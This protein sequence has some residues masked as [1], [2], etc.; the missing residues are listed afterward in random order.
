[1]KMVFVSTWSSPPSFPDLSRVCSSRLRAPSLAGGSASGGQ[2]NSGVLLSKRSHILRLP[3]DS[4]LIVDSLSL[5]QHETLSLFPLRPFLSMTPL[6][7]T[8]RGCRA[9]FFSFLSSSRHPS[10][11]FLDLFV[12]AW[13]TFSVNN[14]CGG[15]LSIFNGTSNGRDNECRRALK[16]GRLV[17][18]TGE[19]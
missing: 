10:E 14:G 15:E 12:N 13:E 17:L 6:K 3:E 1:M 11:A 18:F 5:P 8:E 2:K 9:V 4:C 16:G 7:Q 19:P